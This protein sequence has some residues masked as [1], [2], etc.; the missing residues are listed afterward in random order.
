MVILFTWTSFLQNDVLDF[1]NLHSPLNLSS[2]VTQ[3]KSVSR[4]TSVENKCDI[5]PSDSDISTPIAQSED[6]GIRMKEQQ[7]VIS[8]SCDDIDGAG[9]AV[10]DPRA[11]QDIA[12]QCLL[13]PALLNFDAEQVEVKFMST[14]F[15]CQVCF[16]EKVG[17]LCMKFL[18]CDHVYCKE[19]MQGFF[20]VLIKEGN[21]QGLICPYPKC[22]SQ[23]Y[24]TQVCR[25]CT[26]L[27]SIIK[28]Y[29]KPIVLM[30]KAKFLLS[31][32]Q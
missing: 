21:V 10:Y 5:S 31:G 11:I 7:S 3:K 26:Y 2:V 4:T 12:S 16:M 6:R 1:L 15:E 23:A 18:G 27:P 22:E 25:W 17:K 13:L 9:S 28:A 24:P 29:F 30:Y 8:A 32:L 19:C 14:L 20:E